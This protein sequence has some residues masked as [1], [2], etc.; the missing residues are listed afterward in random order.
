M[1]VC[2]CVC[3]CVGGVVCLCGGICVVKVSL[4]LCSC[5]NFAW[6]AQHDHIPDCV[7]IG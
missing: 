4:H 1:C 3:V 7:Y 6:Q 5:I 2:G